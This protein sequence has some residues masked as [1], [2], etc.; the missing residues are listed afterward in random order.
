MS[1]TTTGVT[2]YATMAKLIENSAATRRRLD[3]LTNQV[4]TGLI[5]DTYAGLGTG[6]SVSLNLRPQLANLQTWQNNVDVA[7]GHMTVTQTALTQLQSIAA[8]YYAQLNAVQGVEAGA[9]DSI[10]ASARDALNQV[11]NLLDTKDGDVYVFAGQDTATPPISDPS[12]MQTSAFFTAI[13]NA[14]GGLSANGAAATANATWSV[15]APP[16]LGTGPS[17][18]SASYV[19]SRARLCALPRRR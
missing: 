16:P 11:A 18:F 13:Q 2:G 4:S 9:V 5:G 12:N 8:G 3:T 17:P 7:T 1:I 6:A 15:A 19:C 14:V 10:A